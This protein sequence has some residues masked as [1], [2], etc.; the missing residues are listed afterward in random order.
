V[1]D[2]S[3][4]GFYFIDEQYRG[5]GSAYNDANYPHTQHESNYCLATHLYSPTTHQCFLSCHTD[6]MVLSVV[7]CRY[8]T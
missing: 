4:S 5:P 3:S 6:T 8:P 7:T 2:V 1:R